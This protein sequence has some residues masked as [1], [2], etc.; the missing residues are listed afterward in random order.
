MTA[1]ITFFPVD[2]GDM[3][4]ITL[5]SGRTILIDC[6]IRKQADEGNDDTFDAAEALRDRLNRDSSGRLNVDVMVL[7]HPDRDHCL[8]LERH[9]HLGPLHGWNADDDKIVIREMWSSP[10]VFRRASM[11]LTLVPDAKAWNQEARRRVARYRDDPYSVPLEGNRI[12]ILGE[13]ENGKTN[14]IPN[15]VVR[16]D[17]AISHA[18]GLD[19]GT[20]LARLLGPLPIAEGEEENE[21]AKNRSSIILRFTLTGDGCVNAGHYLAGGDAEVGVWSRLWQRH[22]LSAPDW[23]EYDILLSPHHCSWHSL[24]YDSWS[25]LGS[26][27]QVDGNARN[28][29]SRTRYGAVIIAS[30]NEIHDDDSDPPCIGAKNE[31]VE[32]VDG[33]EDRFFCTGDTPDEVLEFEISVLGPKKKARS[34]ASVAA[35]L[36][37]GATARTPRDH[38]GSWQR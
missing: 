22:G 3:T 29:L 21:L 31:Y 6:N 37:V 20:F 5:D 14:D 35:V 17:E 30:S 8:G 24:S 2:N 27:G 10:M 9:F 26:A 18:N 34:L 11:R 32:I 4:L 28:A 36:G 15:I 7:S 12:L 16:V 38:G 33:A 1:L 25:E 19:D 13:D 23:L